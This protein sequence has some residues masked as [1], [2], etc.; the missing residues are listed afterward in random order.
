MQPGGHDTF[1]GGYTSQE[2]ERRRIPENDQ[3]QSESRNGNDKRDCERSS[4][5]AN[6]KRRNQIEVDRKRSERNRKMDL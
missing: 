1:A 5:N 6:R 4:D 2:D 3:R